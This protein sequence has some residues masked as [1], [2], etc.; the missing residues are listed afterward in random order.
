MPLPV[1]V[2]TY[3][4]TKRAAEAIIK[5]FGGETFIMRPRG[6]FGPGDPHLL[7]RLLRVAARGPLPLL[8]GGLALLD[9]THVDVAAHAALAMCEARAAAAGTYNIAHGEPLA[10]RDLVGRLMFGLGRRLKWRRLPVGP[11]LLG[12][13]VLEGLARLDPRGR[14]PI[15]TAYALGL[16]A[17]SHTLDITKAKARL[18]WSPPISLD[19]A[20]DATVLAF[21]SAP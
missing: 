15:V 19:Q 14:E 16:F 11:A 20:I 12:A 6:L 21:R 18:G 7:P 1:P 9:I 3:A 8:R 5:G 10:V 17:F 2:N 13:R 4:A